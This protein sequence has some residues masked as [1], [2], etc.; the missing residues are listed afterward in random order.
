MEFT[1]F[2]APHCGALW[3]AAVKSAKFH[4]SKVI[5]CH[6]HTF[7]EYA[8]IAA[9]IEEIP[10]SRPL[11]EWSADGDVIT[12]GH[13]L[14]GHPLIAVPEI[15]EAVVSRIRRLEVMQQSVCAF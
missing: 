13:F 1:P 8:M 3:K 5:G 12:L 10:N 14:I 15:P 4:L 7:E 6:T 11:C 2:R 9:E